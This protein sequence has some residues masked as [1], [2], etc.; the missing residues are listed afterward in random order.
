[1]FKFKSPYQVDT[2]IC[3]QYSVSIEGIYDYHK[4][5]KAYIYSVEH[6]ENISDIYHESALEK[7]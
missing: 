2:G 4:A 5:N 6:M 7:I 3:I 1:M